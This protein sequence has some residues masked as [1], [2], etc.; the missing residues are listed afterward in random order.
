MYNNKFHTKD[1]ILDGIDFEELIT[2]IQCNEKE[3]R[4]ETVN[5]VFEEILEIKLED[6]R[7]V[8]KHNINNILKECL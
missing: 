6:A 8:L 3:V 5:K 7:E 2:T 4:A 1:S